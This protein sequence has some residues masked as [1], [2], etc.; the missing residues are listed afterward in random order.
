MV[1]NFMIDHNLFR[2]LLF[3]RGDKRCGVNDAVVYLD[4][5]AD[6]GHVLE[7]TL[8]LFICI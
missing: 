4:M 8:Y 1:F 6:H 2:N 5:K 7:F 3:F